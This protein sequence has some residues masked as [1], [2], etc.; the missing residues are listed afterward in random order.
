MPHQGNR[1]TVTFL[2][3]GDGEP[4]ATPVRL[5]ISDGRYVEVVEGLHEGDR[6]ITGIDAGAGGTP[7]PNASPSTNPFAPTRPSPRVR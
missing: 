2:L 6:V 7:R 1:P 5:G 4:K 3:G